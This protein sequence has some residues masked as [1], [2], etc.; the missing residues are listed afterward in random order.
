MAKGDI[1]TSYKP[2]GCGAINKL[3]QFVD[4]N[5]QIVHIV[6]NEILQK[7]DGVDIV[8]SKNDSLVVI[9]VNGNRYKIHEIVDRSEGYNV[10]REVVLRTLT[11]EELEQV[12][13]DVKV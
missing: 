11:A 2:E 5:G 6:K 10:T 4:G 3:T 13:A 7:F 1:R 12:T 8:K 9:N